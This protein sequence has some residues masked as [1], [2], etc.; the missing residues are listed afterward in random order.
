M[1]EVSID[2]VTLQNQFSGKT[3]KVGSLSCPENKGK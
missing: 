2:F 1:P 3:V